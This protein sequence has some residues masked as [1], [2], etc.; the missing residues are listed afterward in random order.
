MERLEAPRTHRNTGLALMVAGILM[1][2]GVALQAIHELLWLLLAV[3]FIILVGALPGLRSA[4][5]G[6]EGL[7]GTIAWWPAMVAGAIVAVLLIVGLFIDLVLG[8]DP[9]DVIGPLFPV[10][11]V[12][13]FTFVVAIALY[14]VAMAIAGVVPR[15]AAFLV[16]AALPLALVIDM[17]TGAFF[18][19]NGETTEWG[20]YIGIPLFAL[21]FVW[22]GYALWSGR[23][24]A[25]TEPAAP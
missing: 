8:R 25:T 20:F 12:G 11:A 19:E 22:I 1:V 13:F 3:G 10:L 5:G 21:G 2:A 18:E 7:L 24:G 15:I 4:H 9:E 23:A 6:R 14:G 16:A 17:A